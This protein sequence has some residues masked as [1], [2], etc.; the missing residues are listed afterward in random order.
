MYLSGA[1]RQPSGNN[2]EFAVLPRAAR[3]AHML[4]ITFYAAGIIGSLLIYHSGIMYAVCSPQLAEQIF[5]SLAGI[6]YPRSS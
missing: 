3:P 5:T 1:M 6:S 2:E 4:F